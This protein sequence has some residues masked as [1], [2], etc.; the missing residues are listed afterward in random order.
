MSILASFRAAVRF[1]ARHR[2]FGLWAIVTLAVACG[3]NISVYVLVRTVLMRPLP[4]QNPE[5]LVMVWQKN[6]DLAR[7]F[8]ID[9]FLESNHAL[10]TLDD[11]VRTSETFETLGG[12]RN[13]SFTATGGSQPAQV[14]GMEVSSEFFDTLG[15]VTAAGRL[16]DR[17]EYL[18]GADRVAV[19]SYGFWRGYFGG[20][21]T[22][23]GHTVHLDGIPYLVTGVM[24]EGFGFIQG[25]SGGVAPPS[26]IWVPMQREATESRGDRNVTVIG[27]LARG[28]GLADAQAELDRFSQQLA[29]TDPY[30]DG[31]WSYSLMPYREYVV[32]H[33]RSL[34]WILYL[35]VSLIVIIAGL[36]IANLSIAG[37]TRRERDFALRSAVGASRAN[38]STQVV[39]ESALLSAVGGALGVVLAWYGLRLF[40]PAIEDRFPR[41][42]EMAF[43]ATVVPYWL[44]LVLGAAILISLPQLRRIATIG[45]IPSSG[46][47]SRSVPL[48]QLRLQ[49]GMIAVQIGMTFAL[50]GGAALLGKGL[51]RLSSAELGFRVENI[52]IFNLS[53]PPARY[54]G[55]RTV[56]F[57]DRLLERVRSIP[58]V[59]SAAAVLNHP[60]SGISSSVGIALEGQPSPPNAGPVVAVNTVTPGYFRTMGIP[61]LSG[62]DFSR[63]DG[64]DQVAI[65]S[66]TGSKVLWDGAEPIGKRIRMF[67]Q[68]PWVSIVGVAADI[69]GPSPEANPEPTVYQPLGQSPSAN[70]SIVM[71]VSNS[72]QDLSDLLQKQVWTLDTNL[73]VIVRSAI[74][75]IN[76]NLALPRLRTATLGLLAV[77]AIALSL[78]GIYALV[79][80]T[81]RSRL[82]EIGVRMAIG[83]TRSNIVQGVLLRVLKWTGV[84]ILIGAL[85]SVASANLLASLLYGVSVDDGWTWFL[86]ASLTAAFGLAAAIVPAVRASRTDPCRLL[87]IE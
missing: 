67:P 53:L 78:M 59:R 33:S 50:M 66:E 65:V 42:A 60:L 29:R 12:F 27:R 20:D 86:V 54:T 39:L 17:Q 22:V 19:L 41:I 30:T 79:S 63:S 7:Q 75:D 38:L 43:D 84:G 37:M 1:A 4:Y 45:G 77:I 76:D 44:A 85:L 21:E 5:R 10:R 15:A 28:A 13:R 80:F 81:S 72:S 18:P 58:G 14:F 2:A 9:A 73:P 11:L 32:R 61:V 16:P 3:S 26:R 87:R 55:E 62:S 71:H 46:T 57:Y 51:W 25:G 34:L 6:E 40:G 70:M 8:N 48:W 74:Q 69:A 52:E 31:G 24:K 68:G 56:L 47:M 64:V 49:S 82:S 83:A 36:N 23:P 35:A